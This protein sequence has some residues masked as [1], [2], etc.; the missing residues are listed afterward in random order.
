MQQIN[1]AAS[2]FPTG[3]SLPKQSVCQ[4]RG[5]ISAFLLFIT[6]NCLVF[7]AVCIHDSTVLPSIKKW[8][9]FSL[10]LLFQ[11][12][13]IRV[14]LPGSV[15][16]SHLSPKLEASKTGQ[17]YLSE[18]C[19]TPVCNLYKRVSATAPYITLLA[20]DCQLWQHCRVILLTVTRFDGNIIL[21]CFEFL[22]RCKHDHGPPTAL[23]FLYC[24]IVHPTTMH[25]PFSPDYLLQLFL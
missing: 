20:S 15:N 1:L 14:L 6:S 3:I 7:R 9:V 22:N 18:L 2:S 11:Y 8:N 19:M 17:H 13:F 4:H 5:S 25:F 23:Y 12:P 10:T 21:V 24:R 16:I